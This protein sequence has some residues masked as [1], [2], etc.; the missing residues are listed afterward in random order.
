M[1]VCQL[2]VW[3]GKVEGE[4]ER[5]LRNNDFDMI[6]MQEVMHA[7]KGG[8]TEEL[9]AVVSSGE[10]APLG[11]TR[12]RRGEDE[13]W[14]ED[15]NELHLSRLCFEV[16]RILRASGMPYY[17]FSAN[18]S[19]KIGNSKFDLGNLILSKIPIQSAESEFV[20]GAYLPDVILKATPSNALN[21]Q[22]V[23]LENGVTVI[24]HHGFW[25]KIP[26]GDENTVK[27]FNNLAE[28]IKKRVNIKNEPVIFCGDLNIIHESPAMRAL[29]FL[30]DLTFENGVKNTLSGLK[31]NGEVACDHVMINDKMKALNFEV[32]QSNASDHCPVVADV[33]I[34][35]GGEEEG[36]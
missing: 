26:A 12:E 32:M 25:R 15:E 34:I 30:T 6:C 2:N 24:N 7:H 13:I 14:A 20:N 27:A 17:Y 9:G 33:E 28:I 29:D 16:S 36:K 23:R 10:S 3:M 19:S 18:W 4:L 35:T 11:R 8:Q 1:R 21:V 31:F 5:F 22:I